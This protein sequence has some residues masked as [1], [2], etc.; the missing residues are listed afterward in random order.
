[1]K[2]FAGVVL[3]AVLLFNLSS[4]VVVAETVNQQGPAGVHVE[5]V[6]LQKALAKAGFY[7]GAIDGIAGRRTKSSLRAFQQAN[8]LSA[9]GIC[10]AK[11]WDKLKTYLPE[12]EAALAP[13]SDTA[14]EDLTQEDVQDATSNLKHK[15]V[16]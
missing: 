10:G 2:R 15:L 3:A 6:Q 16:S 1:M 14:A 8:G 13:T 7:T 9:D 4:V 5:P 11:T 12:E